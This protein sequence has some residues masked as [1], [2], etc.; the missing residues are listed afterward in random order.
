M[1][2]NSR[3]TKEYDAEN[4]LAAVSNL[5][6]NLYTANA[7]LSDTVYVW[8]PTSPD[9]CRARAESAGCSPFSAKEHGTPRSTTRTD[10]KR[11]Q[12]PRRCRRATV[13]LS[14]PHRG[15]ARSGIPRRSGICT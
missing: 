3:V 15:G 5:A 1:R 7:P 6:T 12:S 13:I 10:I 11:A 9:Q 4:R 14:P 8:T 2:K